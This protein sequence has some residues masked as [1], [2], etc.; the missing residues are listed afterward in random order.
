VGVQGGISIFSDI[1]RKINILELG[2]LQGPWWRHVPT[3]P[4]FPNRQQ[5]S[6]VHFVP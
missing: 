3:D 4:S 1:L 6:W 2:D 5:D